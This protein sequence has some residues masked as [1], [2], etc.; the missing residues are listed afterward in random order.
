MVSR[1]HEKVRH[2]KQSMKR[3]HKAQVDEHLGPRDA[4]KSL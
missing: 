3:M 1:D 2:E 4:S